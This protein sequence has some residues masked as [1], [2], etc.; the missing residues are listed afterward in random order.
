MDIQVWIKYE[1]KVGKEEKPEILQSQTLL[2]SKS[3]WRYKRSCG[4]LVYIN[5]RD[6]VTS[7][8]LKQMF[9]PIKK[10]KKSNISNSVLK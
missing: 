1:A 6:H 3:L 10:K 8:F 9:P 5:N 7:Y 2:P 4:W